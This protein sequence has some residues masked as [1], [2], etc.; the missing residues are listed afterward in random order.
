LPFA[1]F[2]SAL[3]EVPTASQLRK[4][5]IDLYQKALQ[6]A[7][8]SAT[9]PVSKDATSLISYNLGLTDKVMILCP[10]TSEG[11]KIQSNDGELIGPISLN[12]TV[13][14]GTLLVK[15]GAE[16]DALRSDDVKLH[17]VLRSVGID[18]T[19]SAPNERL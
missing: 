14:G 7:G 12:G 10:R 5:Y 18:P 1:Y 17:D 11:T 6:M 15:S 9:A 8:G 13:L 4:I 3:P 2:A 16:W 19:K